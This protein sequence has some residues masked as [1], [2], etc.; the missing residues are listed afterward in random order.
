VTLTIED[1]IDRWAQHIPKRYRHSM[2][3]FGLFSPRLWNRVVEAAFLNCRD[4]SLVLAGLEI[5]VFDF[6][7]DQGNSSRQILTHRARKR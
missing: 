6:P 4:S 2:R 3:Y 1:F 5:L 7:I